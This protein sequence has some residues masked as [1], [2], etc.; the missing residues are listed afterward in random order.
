MTSSLMGPMMAIKILREVGKRMECLHCSCRGASHL[1]REQECQ[2][3]S[4][5]LIL[6][7]GLCVAA[8]ADGHGGSSYFR[9]AVGARLAVETT[10]EAARQF[11]D[12]SGSLL[13]DKPF[14]QMPALIDLPSDFS[15][16]DDDLLLRQLFSS[17]IAKW[18]E[19][20]LFHCEENGATEWEKEHVREDLLH[21]LSDR[22]SL[23][24]IYGCTLIAY[25]QT[26]DYWIAFQIGDGKLLTYKL[27]GR[28][29]GELWQQPVPWDERCFLNTTTSL[30]DVDAINE[31]RYCYEGDGNY[32]SAVFMGSDG[33]DNTFG[34]G[35]HLEKFYGDILSLINESSEE[36]AQRQLMEVLPEYSRRG[37]KDDMSVACMVNDSIQSL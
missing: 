15:Y 1:E 33:L 18:N 14:T 4:D 11:V 23:E 26:P 17:I 25:I 32:P 2:D 5:A 36:E 37:S 31:F 35:A 20:I 27:D 7:D 19:A 28:E 21:Q 29:D 6:N 22:R 13:K 16:T 8:V 24:V 30:C 9:S 3:Y 34:D 10:I 12:S